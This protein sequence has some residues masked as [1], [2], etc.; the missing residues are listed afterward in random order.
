[1]ASKRVYIDIDIVKSEL[2]KLG[3]NNTEE[4]AM[5]I[6]SKV[7]ALISGYKEMHYYLKN[8]IIHLI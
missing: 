5:A 1:M 7:K 2:E 4:A 6:N 8:S 3:V